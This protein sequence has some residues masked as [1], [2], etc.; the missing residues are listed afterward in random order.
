L[1]NSTKRHAI[2]RPASLFALLG[3]AAAVTLL[4]VHADGVAVALRELGAGVLWMGP[5][6]LLHLAIGAVAWGWVIPHRTR[7][8]I[9]FMGVWVAG[10]LNTV[11]PSATIGGEVAKARVL[12]RMG[13]PGD[14]AVS[15]V[16]VDTTTQAMSMAVWGVIGTLTLIA[17]GVDERTAKGAGLVA[18]LF[19]LGTVIFGWMQ[20]R[21]AAGLTARAIRRLSKNPKLI[22][23][24][25]RTEDIDASLRALYRHPGR[26]GAATIVR[27][28]ARISLTLEVWLAAMLMGA[29]ITLFEALLVKSVTGAARGMAF[30]VPNGYGVQEFAFLAAGAAIGLEPG[31]AVALAMA[32]R[33]RELIF[34]LPALWWWWRLEKTQR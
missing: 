15:S 21:G 19:V 2:L 26:I 12:V 32:T 14:A 5:V 9:R 7:L 6:Y 23:L 17:V 16:V 24:A 20:A 4:V 13:T 30:V 11:I 33:V 29:P 27:L 10:S 25:G 31:F 28:L 22:A 1:T 18:V 34:S 8:W 3:V